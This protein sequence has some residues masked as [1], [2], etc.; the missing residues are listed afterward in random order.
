[1]SEIDSD[2]LISDLKNFHKKRRKTKNCIAMVGGI[3]AKNF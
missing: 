2:I 3:K 1:M